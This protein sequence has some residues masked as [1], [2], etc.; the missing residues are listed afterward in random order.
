MRNRSSAPLVTLA[1]TLGLLL[2][3]AAAWAALPKA[4]TSVRRSV[5]PRHRRHAG[6]IP[7][8]L[9]VSGPRSAQFYNAAGWRAGCPVPA[10]ACGTVRTLPGQETVLVSIRRLGPTPK[11]RP[12]RAR[13]VRR[14]RR[15]VVKQP[16]FHRATLSPRKLRGKLQ[17]QRRW[18]YR[19]A[20]PRP[21]GQYTLTVKLIDR[22]R[23]RVRVQVA[24]SL[25]FTVDT[26]PPL[27][28][29]I[30]AFPANPT[31][32]VTARLT[33]SAPEPW[34]GYQ[35]D[36]D[37]QLWHSCQSPVG[38]AGLSVAGH[39]FQV[40]AVDRAGNWSP[41]ATYAWTVIGGGPAGPA[42]PFTL[43]GGATGTL[44]PGGPARPVALRV[45]NANDAPIYLTSLTASLR[46]SSLPL[47]C[48]ASDYRII[49]PTLPVSGVYVPAHTT[50]TLSSATPAIQMVETGSN[51]DACRGAQ[52]V[53]DYAGT[54]RS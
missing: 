23:K 7:A 31:T 24:R 43:S 27:A 54:A 20:L 34:L 35:C 4:G 25:P 28:P 12:R 16:S 50:L 49:Q 3:V 10:G 22:R 44:Y 53:L 51:Q 37:S 36:L 13:R 19:F 15:H 6:R 21:D 42:L 32:V 2:G 39:Q 33:F 5:A 45:A 11:R 26:V 52:L 38:Y 17:P 40:R 29:V 14:P 8:L 47:G 48:P 9:S 18:S 30:T 46:T 41:S 1:V